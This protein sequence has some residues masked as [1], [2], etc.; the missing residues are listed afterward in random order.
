MRADVLRYLGYED[1]GID[2]KTSTALE[3]GI[4]Y[5]ENITG[6]TVYKIYDSKD[7]LMK[8]LETSSQSLKKILNGCEKVVI[9]AATLG[10]E[11][12]KT[13]RT[14]QVKSLSEGMILNA[15]GSGRIEDIVESM[16]KDIEKKEELFAGPPYSPGYGDLSLKVQKNILSVLEGQKR[17]GIVINKS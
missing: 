6:S 5:T 1:Q 12:E 11:F 17:I 2:L 14:W 4:K 16:I 13:L 7:D 8:I 15:C 9:F 3:E 10:Q